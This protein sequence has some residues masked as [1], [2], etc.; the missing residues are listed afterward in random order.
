MRGPGMF[1]T[2]ETYS[3]SNSWSASIGYEAQPIN[4][5]LGVNVE[6]SGSI[7]FEYEFN[8]PD[9]Y[10]YGLYYTDYYQFYNMDV[11]T[12]YIACTKTCHYWSE[13]GTATA[14]VF[15]RRE[16]FVQRI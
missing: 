11:H 14:R 9:N 1:K 3:W 10:S 13:Y 7:G 12:E 6:A 15:H 16:Y 8:L 4:I 5:A 2:S